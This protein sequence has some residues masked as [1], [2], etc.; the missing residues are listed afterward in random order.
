MSM[1]NMADVIP[2]V[3]GMFIAAVIGYHVLVELQTTPEMAPASSMLEQG[4][5]TMKFVDWMIVLAMFGLGIV[6]LILA[7]HI[8]SHP[9][10]FAIGVLALTI[11]VVV[12]AVFANAYYDFSSD[13][14]IAYA[15]SQFQLTYVIFQN[16]PTIVLIYGGLVAIV[17]YGKMAGG[18]PSGGF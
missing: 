11:T 12:A 18:A 4:K 13:A 17:I 5:E 14:Q 1:L 9:A 8:R 3:F 16:L 10:L 2:I 7:F 6:V 15:A